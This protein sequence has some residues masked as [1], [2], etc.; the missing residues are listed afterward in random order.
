MK[1]KEE[2]EELYF[3]DKKILT[4]IAEKLNVSVSYVTKILKRNEM[5]SIEKEKRK[6]E[7]CMKRREK[8]KHIIYENRKQKKKTDI[9]Y[10]ALKNSHEQAAKELSQGKIIGTEALRKWCSSAYKYN[11]DKRRYEFDAGTSIR[12]IDLPQYIKV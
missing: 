8:Q 12:S 6:K 9:S 7:N 5:Y 3:K 11:P 1:K 2:I 10:Q 4:E